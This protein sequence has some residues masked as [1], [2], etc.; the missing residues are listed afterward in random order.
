MVKGFLF[1][2]FTIPAV[3]YAQVWDFGIPEKLAKNINTE[4]EEAFPLLTP[5]GKT[6]YFTRVLYP[7]NRGGKFSGA[8]A[9]VSSFDESRQTWGPASNTKAV[10]NDNGTNAVIGI[11]AKGQTLY[12]MNTSANKKASGIY[13]MKKLSG[14][15]SK[16]ELIPIEGLDPLGFLSFYVS[17]DF[18]VIFI[19]MKGQDSRGEEDLYVSFKKSSGEWTKPKNLGSSVNTTGFEISPF[20]SADKKRLYFSSNGH[21][22]FG[23]ADIFYC[24]RL[25]NTW[26]TWSA[27][28]NLGEKLNTK[29]FDAYFSVYGDSLAYFSSNRDSNYADLYKIKLLPGNEVL[30]FGQRYLTSNEIARVLGAQ[31]SRRIVFDDN[32]AALTAPQKELLFFIANKLIENDAINIQLSVVEENNAALSEARLNAVASQLKS[33]GVDNIR[34]L[35]TNNE[36]VKKISKSQGTIEILL[37]K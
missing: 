6:L 19:S 9:W 33:N 3:L 21:K 31:V 29:K 17:P 1:L 20:L 35:L 22:G 4:Y 10:E 8:D 36:R 18:E 37:Y 28:R 11:D 25:Y 30:A 13:F 12:L 32:T 7:G 27:P 34:I 15:W 2:L 26:D 16:P 5:D 24:D 23:D 14:G